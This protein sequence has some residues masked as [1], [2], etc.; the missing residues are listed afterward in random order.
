MEGEPKQNLPRKRVLVIAYYWPPAGGPGVQRWLKFTKYLP[1]NGW[2][3]EL[4]VPQGA[5]YP[6]LDDSLAQ[7]IDHNLA[8]HR[9]PIFEPYEAVMNLF[10]GSGKAER[11]GSV[12]SKDEQQSWTQYAMLWGRGN[13]LLPDPRVL[14]RRKATKA[15]AHI[16]R[17]ALEEGRPFDAIATTGPPHS[18]HLIGLALKKKWDI[19]WLADFRDLWREMD[20]LEDF[21]PTPRTRRRHLEME[22]AVVNTADFKTYSSPSTLFSLAPDKRPETLSKFE[23]IYNGWDQ[24]DLEDPS[25]S[26]RARTGSEEEAVFQL[27]HFGSLF[28][29]RDAPGLWKAIRQWNANLGETRKRIHL[30]LA[31]TA[32]RPVVSSLKEHMRAED[33]TDHGYL[34][35]GDAVT[36]MQRMDA[37]LLIQN[38]NDT[39][40]KAIPGKAFEYLATQRPIGV[41]VPM[42]SDLGDLATSWQL[43]PCAHNDMDSAMEMLA[44]LQSSKGV[45][46]A[47]GTQ[48]SRRSLTGQ[49]ARCLD[50]MIQH[51]STRS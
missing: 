9:V 12:A 7:E 11:L 29:T 8:V 47:I 38:D 45:D 33:W 40:R 10:K 37:L 44:T 41:I 18:V 22:R 36:M 46:P 34:S 23:L 1:E 3:P 50:G 6:V 49:L 2:Q 21:H 25:P 27:G 24:D 42:P 13:L 39:G 28:P 26:H 43:K 19:P 32:S 5:A 16:L 48:F 15:A 51:P 35:H 14:W 31:G 30:N 20:Y 17:S 4:L